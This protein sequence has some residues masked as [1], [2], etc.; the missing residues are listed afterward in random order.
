SREDAYQFVQK[1]AMQSWE[2]EKDFKE[3]LRQDKE[4]KKYLSSGEIEK[5]FDLSYYLKNVNYIFKRVFR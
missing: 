4:V 5:L 1:N 2:Q 3:F